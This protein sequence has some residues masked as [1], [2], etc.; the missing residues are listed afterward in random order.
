MGDLSAH[1]SRVE[2]DCHDGTKATP[3][4]ALIAALEKLRTAIGRPVVI[5]SGYRT[6]A[7][8]ASI[9]GAKDS[10]HTHNDAADISSRLGVTVDQAR[11][12][13]FTG[14]GVRSDGKVVHVDVRPGRV[15]VFRDEARY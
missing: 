12:A 14:I 9:G 6:K 4:P 15:V 7:Y 3:A 13:G 10:R 1:F 8:N 11:K 2:F 5:V